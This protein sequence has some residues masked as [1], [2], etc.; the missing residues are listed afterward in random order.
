MCYE[1]KASFVKVIIIKGDEIDYF[2]LQSLQ[3]LL[4]Q[5]VILYLKQNGFFWPIDKQNRQ[6]V[7]RYLHLHIIGDFSVKIQNSYLWVIFFFNVENADL[8]EI[9]FFASNLALVRIVEARSKLHWIN[10][11]I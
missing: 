8:F 10:L 7:Q 11:L 6:K 2:P 9:Y 5:K 1:I 4:N 3:S